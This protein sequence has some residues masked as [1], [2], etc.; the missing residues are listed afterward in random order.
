MRLQAIG[1]AIRASPVPTAWAAR[2]LWPGCR[3]SLS[4]PSP[5]PEVTAGM[6]WLE[7]CG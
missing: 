7:R 6:Q 3:L 2:A 4:F 5:T 1:E